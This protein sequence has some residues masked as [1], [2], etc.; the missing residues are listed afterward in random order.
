MP[1]RRVVLV[2]AAADDAGRTPVGGRTPVAGLWLNTGHGTLGWTHGGGLG[3]APGGPDVGAGG[4]AIEAGDLGFARYLG[5][6]SAA[7]G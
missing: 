1:R 5:E 6:R 3:A 2:R 7:A 4:A